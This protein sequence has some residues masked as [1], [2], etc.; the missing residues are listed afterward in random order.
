MNLFLCE[1]EALF[2]D[3]AHERAFWENPLQDRL[4][5]VLLISHA[6]RQNVEREAVGL[7][8]MLGSSCPITKGT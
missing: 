5:K 1:E 7:K 2:E 8:M 4:Y 3:A 6:M